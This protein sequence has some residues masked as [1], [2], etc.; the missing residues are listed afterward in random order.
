MLRFL[1]ISDLLH[2][3]LQAA[4][5]GDGQAAAAATAFCGL[6]SLCFPG[7]A[8]FV[9]P[10]LTSINH[11]TAFAHRSLAEGPGRLHSVSAAFNLLDRARVASRLHSAVA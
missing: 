8:Y 4:L 1:G 7:M 3:I 9:S 10:F 6:A 11:M 2:L 5:W